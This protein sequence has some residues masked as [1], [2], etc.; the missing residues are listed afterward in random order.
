MLEIAR[1]WMDLDDDGVYDGV[2]GFR[3]DVAKEV[4]LSTWQPLRVEM[5]KLNPESFLLGEV[6]DGNAQNLTKWYDDAFDAVFDFPLYHELAGNHDDNMDG[7]L[8]GARPPNMLNSI[9]VGQNALFPPGYQI[10][11]FVNNHD[12]NRALSD[13]GE[14]WKRAQTAATLYLTLPGTPMI[15]YGEEIG[16]LGEKGQGNPYWD[17]Y[18]R[19]PMDW[20][21]AEEGERMT[22]WFRPADRFNAPDDG[23]S[24]EEQQ[25]ETLL[26]NHYRALAELRHAHPALRTG[27]FGKVKVTDGEGVYAFTRHAPASGEHPEEWFLIILNFSNKARSPVLALNLAYPGPFTAV[28]ALNGEAWPEVPADQSYQ[29]DVEPASG[30]V[31]QLSA[32]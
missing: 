5:R 28:D 2:D 1:F 27:S 13:V 22:T 20:Y 7:V 11:R 17:E 15:Y 6:W 4:P 10:V 32:P 23:I 12:T 3:A 29:V 26:I 30:V 25:Q 14:E 16:M 24:V 9:I 21:A 19:E 31:L 8:A 18:R